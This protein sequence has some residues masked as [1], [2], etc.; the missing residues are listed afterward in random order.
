[1]TSDLRTPNGRLS[2]GNPLRLVRYA[3][4]PPLA[5][6]PHRVGKHADH[7]VE[8]SS[9]TECFAAFQDEFDDIET[10]RDRGHLV[11]VHGLQ[12]TGK[13]S[14]ICR[15]VHFLKELPGSVDLQVVDARTLIGP[16][17]TPER[18]ML[19]LVFKI[20]SQLMESP[21]FSGSQSRLARLQSVIKDVDRLKEREGLTADR[22]RDEVATMLWEIGLGSTDDG[23]LVVVI[24]PR[25]A[26]LLDVRFYAE[27]VQPCMLF[28]AE[29]ED[30]DADQ[31]HPPFGGNISV[32][33]LRPRPLAVEDG[34][35]FVR[36]RLYQKTARRESL[37]I[38]EDHIKALMTAWN[39]TMTI[40]LLVEGLAEVFE[41]IIRADSPR[42][43]SYSDLASQ[44]VLPPP[45]EETGSS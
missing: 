44:F 1:M 16:V 11:F 10:I 13:T 39:G 14:L 31:G 4:R 32:I 17:G 7:Y 45:S 35:T 3:D 28:F 42:D 26:N 9:F 20:C 43:V 34:W 41:K 33:P 24:L 2:A 21:H 5:L 36:Q 29:F 15:C 27:V 23:P 12:G 18:R 40:K 19:G 38:R 30:E 37:N 22:V 6:E 8:T 25:S